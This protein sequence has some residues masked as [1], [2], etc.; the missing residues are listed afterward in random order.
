MQG[1]RFLQSPTNKK[2]CFASEKQ[3][4]KSILD[5]LKYKK[6]FCWNVFQ[7]LGCY[8]GCSDI[9]GA[10]PDGRILAIEV[11]KPSGELSR[12]QIVFLENIKAN[13]GIAFVA[14][15]IEDVTLNLKE[16]LK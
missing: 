8:R 1:Q 12:E 5:F 4:K 6:I 7:T 2:V 3:I 16:Y 10:L 14:R 13:N 11:K 15:G 9:L